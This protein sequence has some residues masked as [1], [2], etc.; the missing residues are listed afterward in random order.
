MNNHSN[1]IQT[2]CAELAMR[3]I[4]TITIHHDVCSGITV[5]V[6]PNLTDEEKTFLT[7]WAQRVVNNKELNIAIVGDAKWEDG[8]IVKATIVI[9]CV[10]PSTDLSYTYYYGGHTQGSMSLNLDA[11]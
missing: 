11:M 7:D 3:G 8:E 1:N 6:A 5:E 9:D 4:K 10:K 2:L